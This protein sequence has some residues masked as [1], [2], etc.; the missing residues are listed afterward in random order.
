MDSYKQQLFNLLKE[1]GQNGL[2]IAFSGG[3][4][5]SL[6]LYLACKLGLN[7]L[8]VT[9]QTCLHPAGDIQAASAFAKAL[10]CEHIV[11]PIDEFRD[12][13][14]LENPKNRC[15]LCKH[16]LFSTLKEYAQTRGFETVIDGSNFD[17][18]QE[19]R[20][21]LQAIKELGVISP[22]MQL[23]ITKAQVRQMLKEEGLEV[24]S[25]PSTPCLATRLP[26]GETITKEKIEQ[27]ARAE[28]FLRDMGFAC[29]RVRMHGDIARIEVPSAMLEQALDK[30]EEIIQKLKEVGFLYVTLDLQGFRSGSM[31][32]SIQ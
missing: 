9:F 15:Y 29:C 6:L 5:S 8:A 19:Y 24:F 14:I 26:Y 2:C 10:K 22:L 20:P 3:V 30:R 31:D 11:L 4:D 27:I 17:D 7:V 1:L 23:N 28:A 21:G 32:L 12:A 25:K 18:T 16:L 13:R